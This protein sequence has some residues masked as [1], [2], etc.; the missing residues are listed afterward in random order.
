MK[1]SMIFLTNSQAYGGVEKYVEILIN[2][3][4]DRKIF[5]LSPNKMLKKNS[6]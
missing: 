2:S 5:L 1:N 4:H 6:R 3:I